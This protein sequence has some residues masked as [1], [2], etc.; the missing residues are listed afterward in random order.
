MAIPSSL[1][2]GWF[3]YSPNQKAIW[4]MDNG[5]TPDDMRQVGVPESDINALM[6]FGYDAAKAASVDQQNKLASEEVAVLL[7]LVVLLFSVVQ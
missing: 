4:F 6:Q 7:G 3:N 1:P 5:V 2:T